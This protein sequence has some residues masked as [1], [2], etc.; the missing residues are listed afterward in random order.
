MACNRFR[1]GR[2]PI[3]QLHGV[4]TYLLWKGWVRG[5]RH[6]ALLA[7]I[8]C[9]PQV[10]REVQRF[11]PHAHGPQ[12]LV[13]SVEDGHQPSPL[14]HLAA[15]DVSHPGVPT[16][17][18]LDNPA[19]LP[20]KQATRAWVLVSPKQAL[21]CLGVGERFI[22]PN[23]S[24]TSSGKN[25]SSVLGEALIRLPALNPKVQELLVGL[26]IDLEGKI[27][28]LISVE[29]VNVRGV[30]FLQGPSGL[31]LRNGCT[32]RHGAQVPVFQ[33][34][35]RL[36]FHGCECVE[37]PVDVYIYVGE[38]VVRF[39]SQGPWVRVLQENQPFQVTVTVPR[40]LSHCFPVVQLPIRG[41]SVMDGSLVTVRQFPWFCPQY[42]EGWF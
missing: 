35:Q 5:D 41:P 36:R 27:D 6:V 2:I 9:Q 19:V 13:L 42:R 15:R 3:A 25:V 28:L 23:P 32:G 14:L 30:R 20:Y 39:R 40:P 12:H 16:P 33:R 21:Q 38:G 4:I 29:V 26:F 18:D 1:R 17:R 11:L 22:L 7:G 8:E 37:L 34:A 24:M 31:P 10:R